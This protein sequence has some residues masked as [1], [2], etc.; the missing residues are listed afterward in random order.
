[1]IETYVFLGDLH[2]SIEEY[3][4]WEFLEKKSL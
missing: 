2:M 3:I 1:M 4:Q